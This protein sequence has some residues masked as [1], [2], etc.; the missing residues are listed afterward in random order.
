VP[1]ITISIN[2]V[3]VEKVDAITQPTPFDNAKRLQ[4]QTNFKTADVDKND[5]LNL[6]EFKTFIHLNADQNLGKASTVRRL[7]LY[8]QAFKLADSNGD[9]LVTKNEISAQVQR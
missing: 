2:A 4:I 5:Q 1:T 3:A 6:A 9:G 8:T 7:S